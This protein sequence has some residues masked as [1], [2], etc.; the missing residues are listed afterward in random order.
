MPASGALFTEDFD[1]PDPMPEPEAAAPVFSAAELAGAR[2]AAWRDGRDA[3]LREAAASDAAATRAAMKAFAEQFAEEC[4]AAASRAETAA[5]A[6]TRLLMES[7]AAV[8]PTLCSRYG[9]AEVRAVA[10]TVLPALTPR[11]P[12]SP[13]ARIRAR[14][15]S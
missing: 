14:R 13:C 15:R 6:L 10:R 4:A 8:F 1:K 7:L 3:G 5:E 9:D 2:E 11:N 12:P